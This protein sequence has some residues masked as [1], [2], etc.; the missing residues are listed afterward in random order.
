VSGNVHIFLRLDL[1]YNTVHEFV[2]EFDWEFVRF[3]DCAER[4]AYSHWP[5]C[6]SAE[7]YVLDLSQLLD[8]VARASLQGGLQEMRL[9]LELL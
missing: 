3:H 1:C 9:L 8:R 5:S 4:G 6:E 7:G 2:S